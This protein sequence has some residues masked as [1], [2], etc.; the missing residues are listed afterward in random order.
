MQEK[1]NCPNCGAPIENEI[2]PYCGTILYDF[3]NVE[4]GKSSYLR[5]KLCDKLSVFKAIAENVQIES[6]Y[7]SS[8]FYCAEY[9]LTLEFR[10]VSDES[11]IL[12]KV[13]ER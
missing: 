2:C 6:I 1:L 10:L 3:A 12:L 11:G 8:S 13:F 5:L 4:I 9:L 7:D